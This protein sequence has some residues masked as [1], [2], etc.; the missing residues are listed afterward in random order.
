MFLTLAHSTATVTELGTGIHVHERVRGSLVRRTLYYPL[1]LFNLHR[2][3]AYQRMIPALFLFFT[4]LI[5]AG[6]DA[7]AAATFLGTF[8][9]RDIS[10]S[11]EQTKSNLRGNG[12]KQEIN[13]VSFSETNNEEENYIELSLPIPVVM[14]N[15]AL[16]KD[17]DEKIGSGGGNG[18]TVKGKYD[19]IIAKHKA[20]GQMVQQQ[21]QQVMISSIATGTQKQQQS[22]QK[23][24]QKLESS[25]QQSQGT[26]VSS[27]SGVL[28]VTGGTLDLRGVAGNTSTT[29]AKRTCTEVAPLMGCD[30]GGADNQKMKFMN[31]DFGTCS[32]C[33][34]GLFRIMP[35]KMVR[36][37]FL[38]SVT[39]TDSR[40]YHNVLTYRIVCL[41]LSY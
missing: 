40:Y 27:N 10:F 20:Q 38:E 30:R 28:R 23:A 25:Q 37:C 12:E 5:V 14:Q 7:A 29:P 35:T 22:A 15:R 3:M 31:V 39:L 16:K 41:L 17:E 4:P 8:E 11:T 19:E 18:H 6:S 33:D 21:Q 1:S 24:Q 9:D 13:D 26:V 36:S 32:N 2:T 34:R